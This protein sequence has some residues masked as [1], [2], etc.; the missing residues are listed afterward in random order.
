MK[1]LW[2][3]KVRATKTA[4]IIILLTPKNQRSY[5]YWEVQITLMRY[6]SASGNEWSSSSFQDQ[7]LSCNQQSAD[8]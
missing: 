8:Q 4:T 7:T 1:R 6:C 5:Q 2:L 3:I